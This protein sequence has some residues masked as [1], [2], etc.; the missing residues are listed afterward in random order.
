MPRS[1]S[2]AD[3]N[4]AASVA[5]SSAR[6]L[7]KASINSPAS[8]TA[9]SSHPLEASGEVARCKHTTPGNRSRRFRSGSLPRPCL[10]AAARNDLNAELSNLSFTHN[11]HS[12]DRSRVRVR[13]TCPRPILAFSICRS[14]AS[15]P[16]NPPGSLN[17]RSRK[18]WF[19]LFAVKVNSRPSSTDPRI[20][21]KPVIE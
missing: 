21:A 4:S 12:P 10:V 13:S 2:M 9:I 14:F 18:R 17:C 19:T 8:L 1:R 16:S 6:A 5:P 15:R 20:E 11:S 7:S 3:R